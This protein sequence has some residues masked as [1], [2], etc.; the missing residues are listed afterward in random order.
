M[1]NIYELT[2][3]E[4]ED[5]VKKIFNDISKDEYNPD[6]IIA[7]SRG[8]LL[9]GVL[10]SYMIDVPLIPV[11]VIF[12]DGE[13]EFLFPNVLNMNNKKFL[14]IDDIN[15]TGETFDFLVK[16][17][18]KQEIRNIKFAAVCNKEKGTFKVDYVGACL[19]SVDDKWV[20]F[21]WEKHINDEI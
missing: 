17:F 11:S 19:D 1:D 12:V 8:G 13:N 20:I 18:T 9:P 16:E 7:I 6:Y 10:L 3:K 15:D 14:V 21:P 5:C 2:Y 4:V